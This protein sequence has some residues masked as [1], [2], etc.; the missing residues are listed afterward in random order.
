MPFLSYCQGVVEVLRGFPDWMG[1]LWFSSSSCWTRGSWEEEEE[2]LMDYRFH[3][4]D[5][6]H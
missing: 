4:W 1:K 2:V 6:L 5:G 3:L